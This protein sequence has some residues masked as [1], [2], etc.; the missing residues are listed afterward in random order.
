MALVPG[1]MPELTLLVGGPGSGKTDQVISR[2]AARYEADPFSEAIVL[3]PTVR[4]GDQFRR[5]LVGR[6]GVALRLRVETIAQFSRTLASNARVPS[7]SLSEELLQRTIHNA[8]E[9]GS[10][11]Y[12]KPLAETRGLGSLL[13]GAIGDLLAEGIDPDAFL[14]AAEGSGS[15]SLEALGAIYREYTHDLGQASWTHP[16]Q[17]GAAAADVVKAGADLPGAILLDGFHLFRATE[18]DLLE[19]LAEKAD[20]VVTLDPGAGD[21]SAHDCERLRRRFPNA[22]VTELVGDGASPATVVAGAA[23]DREAQLRAIARQIKQRLTGEAS[24]RPSDFAVAFRQVSPHLGMARQVFSE[25]DLP[26]DPAAGDPLSARPLGA[27]LRRLMHLARDDWRLRDVVAVLSSGFVDRR[28]WRLSR[29]GL[30]AFARR[31]R[32]NNL[33]AGLDA[34]G[35]AVDGLRSD[36][37]DPERSDRDREWLRGAASAMS[38]ALEDLRSLLERPPGTMAE[39]ARHLDEALFGPRAL[40]DPRSRTEP[41]VDVELDALRGQLQELIHTH[42][43]LGGGQERFASFLARLEA[44]FDAPTV[45]LREPGGVLLAPMHTLHGLRFDFVAI[46]GLVE[47]EFPAPRSSH[48]LLDRDAIDVLNRCGLGVPPLARLSEDELWASVSTRGDRVLSLWKTRLNERGRSVAASY[49]YDSLPPDERIEAGMSA[50]E[51]A[52]S[53]RELAIACTCQWPNHGRRRPRGESCWPIVRSAVAVEQRRRSFSDAGEYE[54]R[55]TDGLVPRLTDA[56][57]IWSASRL[58]SYRTCA[59]QF[60]GHYALELREIE[61]ELESADAA[62]R[63]SVVHEILQDAVAPLVEQG[64]PL[65]PDSLPEVL[66]RLGANGPGIWNS[67]PAKMGFGRSAL[68]RLDAED[69]FRKM[70]LLLRREAEWSE[71]S[72]VT[73]IIGAEKEIEASLPLD[74]PLRLK[75]TIDRLEEGED[76]VVIVDYKSGRTISRSDVEEGRRVQLQLYGYAGRDETRA[77][78]IIARYAW[79]DPQAREWD[80]DSSRPEDSLLLDHV[81]EVARQV[82]DAVASGDFRVNPQVP[83][84]TWCSFRHVCRVNGFSRWK[85]D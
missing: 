21:R 55:L 70:E 40:V 56:K 47:G 34:L 61:E 7:H 3:V 80:I 41:G 79:L 71:Q 74:P 81:A 12:F 53:V 19:A 73:R 29:G 52:G 27:W 46:G 39:H 4:H 5:R 65:V 44:R 64:R 38:A 24:L 8:I 23:A 28:R 72:G 59:F 36:A 45:L 13:G 84:P 68:W 2:L 54:G 51:E 1:N 20:V 62:I 75:A 18:M 48:S 82:R 66:A 16:L 6:C 22:E 37:A 69:T 77:G 33:W 60:F 50:P 26:L 57:A 58:E 11:A 17:I 9:S 43:V 35:R 49:Y 42:E 14:E 30:A 15:R 78:R 32:R 83:C 67:A 85:W 76:R 25:Y 10:A 31:A 63:G